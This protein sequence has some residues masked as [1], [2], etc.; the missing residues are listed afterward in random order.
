MMLCL[1]KPILEVLA[2]LVDRGSP[3][4]TSE[5]MLDLQTLGYVDTTGQ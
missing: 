5:Q 2:L 4:L 1:M 3:A